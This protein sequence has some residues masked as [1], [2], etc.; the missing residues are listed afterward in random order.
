M[1]F[2]TTFTEKETEDYNT[3]LSFY[4]QRNKQSPFRIQLEQY[5][6]FDPR[7]QLNTNVTS[8]L[9][10]ILPF[11]S[12]WFLPLSVLF[13]F[14]GWGNIYLRLPFDTGKGDK[15]ESP[16][17]TIMTYTN[18]E[19]IDELWLVWGKK[20]NHIQL[21]WAL[22][23]N[24]TS[25]LLKDGSWFNETKKNR[26]DWGGKGYGSYEWLKENKHKE[27]HPFN[28]TLKSGEKQETEATIVVR[29]RTWK[30][31]ALQFTN[32]FSKTIKDI[33][34]TFNEEVGED[35]GSWKGGVL[36]CSYEMK[37][38]ETPLQTLQRME[39]ERKFN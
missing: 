31:R 29:K 26:L 32:L 3:W 8:L 34:V 5:G 35:R 19:V 9:A 30:R 10:V 11:F 39:K 1:I 24:K 23:W 7:P 18:G 37:P 17:Y 38:G 20:R 21:P 2:K 16:E 13:L 12:L 33:E 4:P 36:G 28:Y 25:T 27:T 22:V 14:Y 15:S 6:Y